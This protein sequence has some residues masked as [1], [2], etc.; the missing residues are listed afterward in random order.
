MDRDMIRLRTEH[1]GE[2]FAFGEIANLLRDEG[3]HSEPELFISGARS[4]EL[5]VILLGS[6]GTLSAVAHVL[7]KF[8]ELR[9]NRSIQIETSDGVTVMTKGASVEEFERVLRSAREP[10]PSESQGKSPGE[11]SQTD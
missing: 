5:L 10:S 3:V 6:G 11:E 4:A 7:Y 9:A 8:L 1:D 2:E